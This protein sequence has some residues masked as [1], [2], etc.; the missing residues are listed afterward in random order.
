MIKQTNTEN[1]FKLVK[2][3]QNVA[4][5]M[6]LLWILN[7]NPLHWSW[8]QTPPPSPTLTYCINSILLSIIN[9]TDRS[10]CTFFRGCMI[11]QD[12]FKW[13]IS[14]WD[15]TTAPETNWGTCWCWQW[16]RWRD[17]S[18]LRAGTR[19]HS[20]LTPDDLTALEAAAERNIAEGRLVAPQ[21]A[22]QDKVEIN[23][24]LKEE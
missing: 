11:I 6:L 16:G 9:H 17:P 2:Q 15:Y 21:S 3:Q 18:G 4:F 10:L 24:G 7:I 12:L 23:G 14:H 20:H 8:Y 5:Y 19:F 13:C 22:K 1:K